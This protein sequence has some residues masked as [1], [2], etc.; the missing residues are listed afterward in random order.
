[1]ATD[2]VCGMRVDEEEALTIDLVSDY[3][4]RTYYFCSDVCMEEFDR[5]PQAYIERQ[6]RR[7]GSRGWAA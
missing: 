5:N 3:G 6:A 2:P 4:D 7:D 1:M